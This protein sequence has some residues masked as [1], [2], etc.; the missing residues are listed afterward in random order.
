MSV[1]RILVAVV[2][3]V[4]LVL[5]V[6]QGSAMGQTGV[7]LI[8]HGSPS[9]QWNRPVLELG[10]QAGQRIAGKSGV[11]A[12]RMAMLESAEPSVDAAVRELEAA[13]CRQIVAVPL[14]IAASEHTLVDVPAALGIYWSPSV[15]AAMRSEGLVP[16]R[17]NVPI[18]LTA[19]LSE[20]S[21]LETYVLRQVQE[22]SKSPRDEAIVLL[23]H[24]DPDH[25]PQIERLLRR[26]V[27]HACGRVG[28][29]YGDW[30]CVGV[31]QEYGA[32][33]IPAI[34]RAAEAKDR[35]LV[36]GLYLGLSAEKLHQR[37]LAQASHHG[38]S[39][40]TNPLDGRDV[41]FSKLPLVECPELLD[42]IERTVANAPVIKGR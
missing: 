24:G 4:F 32:Q 42:W 37:W 19:P 28:V 14:F 9:P 1:A 23:A 6:N 34:Q 30:A 39:K 16:A 12:V 17:T 10:V 29:D 25:Q 20:G 21:L 13:G 22:L 40:E 31:G 5:P 11:K 15:A 27:T 33:G 2:W 8:A 7:L 18:M 41:V 35:V 36:V 26:I 3:G 38:A